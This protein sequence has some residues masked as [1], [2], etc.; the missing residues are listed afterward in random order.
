MSG[1]NYCFLTCIQINQE[2]G[3]LFWYFHIFKN[4]PQFVVI[5]TV[6]SFG[7][8]KI[9]KAEVDDFL[10]LFFIFDDST[11][12][13]NLIFFLFFTL[14]YCIGFVIHQ[15]QSATGVHVFPILNPPSHLPPHTIALGHPS[16]PDLSI[17]YHASNLDWR[18]ISHYDIIHVS[19]PFFQIIPLSPPPTESKKLFYTSVSLL[20]SRIQG[21]HYFLYKFYIC[22]LVYSIDVFLSG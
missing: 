17:L 19:M 12:V 10:K 11:D 13:G 2:A 1:S 15:H 6:K 7:F 4:F 3:E 14:Q 9:N 16:A 5:H 20:L 22:A 21:Y 18:F 8:G